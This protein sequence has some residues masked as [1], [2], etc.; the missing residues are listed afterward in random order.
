MHHPPMHIRP[1]AVLLIVAACSRSN[2]GAGDATDDG[3]SGTTADA[4]SFPEDSSSGSTGHDDSSG[5]SGEAS[6]GST[7]TG[8]ET[9]SGD[10]SSTSGTAGTSAGEST[11]ESTDESSTGSTTAPAPFCG[12]SEVDDGEDCDDGNDQQGDGCD[13]C[14]WEPWQQEGVAHDVPVADLHGWTQCWT[15]DYS[16][17]ADRLVS[18]LAESCDKAQLLIACLP[19]GSDTLTLAAHAPRGDVLSI[20][21]YNAGERRVAN[22]VAWYWA[23]SDNVVG[24]GP[25][26]NTTKCTMQGEDEQLCWTTTGDAPSDTFS[27]GNRC[28]SKLGFSDPE[29]PTW[30]RIVFE[31]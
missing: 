3:S 21:D 9:S 4:S 17:T 13:A 16:G 27:F 29:A 5:G 10:S 18:S 6:G 15:D 31:R 8:G 14:A 20:V 28:G 11:G 25:A 2:P 30:Q 12:D 26:D 24:F 19:L 7:S 22:G 23:P 1:F